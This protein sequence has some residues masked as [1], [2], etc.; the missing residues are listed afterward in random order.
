MSKA[1]PS[2][3]HYTKRSARLFD[4]VVA[5]PTQD[6]AESPF[7]A[8]RYGPM[9]TSLFV[10]KWLSQCVPSPGGKMLVTNN[11]ASVDATDQWAETV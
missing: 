8:R 10:F 1:K 5:G 4:V 6:E 9:I 3:A 7:G 11:V 2:V